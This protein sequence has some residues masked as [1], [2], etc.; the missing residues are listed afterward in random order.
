MNGLI[1][2]FL[3]PNGL[4]F[5]SHSMGCLSNEQE[6]IKEQY[7]DSWKNKGG[8]AWNDWLPLLDKYYQA[9]AAVTDSNSSNF[10]YQ[11][12]NSLALLKIIQ[13]IPKKTNRKKILLSDLEFPSMLFIFNYL[14]K[15]EYE[16]K[17]IKSR[18]GKVDKEQWLNEIDN[19]TLLLLVSF[20]TYGSS[21]RQ[22]IHEIS[23]KCREKNVISVLDIAQSIGVIPIQLEKLG[24]NFAI[25][26]CLKWLCGGTGAGFIWIN[27]ET[28]S[29]LKPFAAGWFGMKNIFAE[30]IEDLIPAT[31]SQCFLDGT[32][33]LLPVMLAISSINKLVNIGIPAIYNH[34]QECLANVMNFIKVHFNFEIISPENILERGATLVF[35]SKN[36][37]KLLNYLKNNNI[38]MDK[39]DK[40]GLRFSPHIYNT[41]QEVENFK[42]ILKNYK[43]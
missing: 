38:Y 13:A 35:R 36:D 26:S 32:P 1:D 4:Y 11:S 27:H 31:S 3:K 41:I 30:N 10:C 19:N 42:N 34:N 12:N 9:L 6:N 5:L 7:F 15:D 20:T 29:L 18:N 17:I 25:G 8:Y 28:F 23:V 14:P 39:K 22:P 21:F 37:E 2:S 33:S 24:F 16:L 40:Y 43:D